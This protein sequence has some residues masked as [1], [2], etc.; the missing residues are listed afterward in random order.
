M[1][2]DLIPWRFQENGTVTERPMAYVLVS[3]SFTG[4]RSQ[5]PCQYVNAVL[6]DMQY[7]GSGVAGHAYCK[8]DLA[9]MGHD[10]LDG[11]SYSL[12]RQRLPGAM[13]PPV[14]YADILGLGQNCPGENSYFQGPGG[15]SIS[16]PETA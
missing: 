16:Q 15:T 12:K 3:P 4:R 1:T 2:P 9:V 7:E 6:L 13:S 14:V 5:V 8:H 11:S 10:V